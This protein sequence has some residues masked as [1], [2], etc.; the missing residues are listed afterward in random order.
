MLTGGS[1]LA[2]GALPT[3]GQYVAG[4]GSIAGST[5]GLTINQATSHGIINWQGFSIGAGNSVLFN[6]GSGST[7][8]RIIGADISKIDGQLSATGSLYLIN[9]QGIVIGP[10]GKVVT[11]G[12]FVAST[13]DISNSAFMSGRAMTAS[14]TS[15]GD[16][17]NAGAIT[18][19]NGDAILVGRSVSNSGTISAPNGTA[20][21]AAGNQ[22][23]LQPVGS[24][25]RIAV[26]GG[27]GDATNSG[28]IA[29]AQAQLS[30]AGGNVYAIAGNNGGLVSAT[31]TQTINGHVWLTAGGTTNVSGTVSSTNADG[32]GGTVTARGTDINVSGRIDASAA[33]AGQAGG[34]VSVIATGTT[35]VSGT[36]K[37]QGGQGGAGGYVETSGEHL[38]VADSASIS[39]T[40]PGGTS[41]TWLL[42]PQDFTIG[43][44]DISGAALSS[45]LA[46]SDIV[47]ASSS[48]FLPGFGDITV[49][50][51]VSWTS[52]HTLT[53]NAARNIDVNLPITATNGGLTLNAGG[54]I[55]ASS[56]ISVGQFTL[57]SGAWS[58][59]AASLPSF[60]ATSFTISGGSFLRATGGD[61]S[62]GNPYQIADIYGLQGVSSSLTLAADSFV[63]AN[64]IDASGTSNWNSGAGFAPIGSTI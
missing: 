30:S 13:R 41:G 21:L 55:S 43:G 42:D 27:T 51:V 17:V 15:N 58:Q 62:S 40:A 26:S 60:S 18:S 24:D 11:S 6:N 2:G 59:I 12:S 31:G 57:Q 25:P 45:E 14:G 23:L 34:T 22:I 32:S 49:D 44:I 38:H 61:G 29:A 50:D 19:A 4:Q 28:T 39:T 10:G 3:G 54:T 9:P 47:I 36:I 52:T 53:L 46:S 37:A 35:T 63:L 7:L 33:Q 64:N 5:N 48:G 20:A 16:V 1:A 8:N 56:A